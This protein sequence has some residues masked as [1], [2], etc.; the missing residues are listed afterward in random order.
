M[1]AVKS[2]FAKM[3][4]VSM[5]RRTVLQ[6]VAAAVASMV[7][8]SWLRLRPI[9]IFFL[10]LFL[11]WIY[12]TRCNFRIV[13]PPELQEKYERIKRF[14][15]ENK[16]MFTGVA[17]VSCV[18]LGISGFVLGGFA[19]VFALVITAS[20]FKWELV[21]E[22]E[23]DEVN[24]TQSETDY[25]EFVPDVNTENLALLEDASD[26]DTSQGEDYKNDDDIPQELLISDS[27]PEYSEN[28][29]DDDDDMIPVINIKELNADPLAQAHNVH[30]K[31]CHFKSDS[32]RST[33]SSSSEEES[34]SKG[35]K[36][37]DY[38]KVDEVDRSKR[39]TDIAKA[40][41]GGSDLGAALALQAA[42]TQ[43][44]LENS[45]KLLVGLMQWSG[46]SNTANAAAAAA[47][48]AATVAQQE[49][50]SSESEFEIIE[51]E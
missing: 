29:T 15:E 6:N 35:L 2:K 25:D 23:D 51:N 30:Y 49:L 32:S 19:L 16:A 43:S 4:N 48:A 39:V 31:R 13:P 18:I 14:R 8:L 21:R 47:A 24:A 12:K 27:L 44:L 10:A 50:S 42:T 28:S 5:P 20:A 7:L 38:A 26:L 41:A 45:G 3:L 11:F 33:S 9:S 22:N 34:L 17:S 40:P 1:Q 36:F 37:P 46:A